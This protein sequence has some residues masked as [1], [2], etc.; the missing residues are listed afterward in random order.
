MA[1]TMA[2]FV[3]VVR[4]QDSFPLSTQPMY[5][6]A[7]DR[8]EWLPSAR[9]V[10][11]ETGGELRLP[12]AIVAAT[13]DPLIAESRLEQAIRLDRANEL[14]VDIAGRVALARE[15]RS[16]DTVEIL[17]ERLDLVDFVAAGT[18]P[19]ERRVHARCE[20]RR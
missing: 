12:M 8:I 11:G 19:L 1:I 5:A 2:L 9:G 7:R 17:T 6:T 18:E 3:P 10:D 20:V 15:L 4:D 16:I 14:C 13:D